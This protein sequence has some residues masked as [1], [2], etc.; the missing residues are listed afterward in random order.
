[1]QGTDKY[2]GMLEQRERTHGSFTQ[3]ARLSQSFKS[4][5]RATPGW[6]TLNETQRESLE[7]IALK[8]SRILSGDANFDDHWADVSGYATL[9]V[10]S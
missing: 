8:L 10:E 6:A 1:M 5:M 9:V 2:T 7:M 3:N 4:A